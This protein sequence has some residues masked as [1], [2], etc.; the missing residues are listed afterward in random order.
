MSSAK[1]PHALGF[2]GGNRLLAAL[3]KE[4]YARLLPASVHVRLPQGKVV[5]DVGDAVRHA[6]FPASG[7][8]SLLSVTEDGSTVEVGMIGSEGA[9][10]VS[11]LLRLRDAPYRVVAQLPTHAL[12]VNIELLEREFLRGGRLQDLLLRYTHAVLTQVAQSASC[13]RFHTTEERLCRW[14]LISSDRAHSDTLDLTQSFLA[15]MIGCPRTSVTAIA[16]R[17]QRMN[18]ISYSRGRVRIIDR[19]GLTRLSC[20][21]YR[22]INREIERYLA[23]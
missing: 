2:P 12:R 11:A 6:F 10:G 7:M 22:A 18:L 13:H 19:A 16:A 17:V 8:L 20:E 5:W 21:C 15:E 9:A 4:E 1:A 23:A 3:P 14:L